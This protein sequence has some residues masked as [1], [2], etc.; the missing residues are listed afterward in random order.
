MWNRIETKE[1][2]QQLL[3]KTWFFHDSCIKELHY[4]SGAYVTQDLG[5]YPVNNRRTVMLV[6]QRQFE[7]M[8]VLELEF[9]GL[10]YMRLCPADA[11]HTCEILGATMTQKDGFIYWCDWDGIP[12]AELDTYPGTI[13]CAAECRWRYS[14]GPLGD[15]LI[16][17]PLTQE[18][19]CSTD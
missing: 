2:I 8:P 7:D 18:A 19:E 15:Q 6:L 10:K 1:D 9:S 16:F 14:K 5:M 12:D 13:I 17:R 4:V 3:D 11:K